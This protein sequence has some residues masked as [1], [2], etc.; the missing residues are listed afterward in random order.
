M[1]VIRKMLGTE[2]EKRIR[3]FYWKRG[4]GAI[5]PCG[6]KKIPS[7]CVTSREKVEKID[8]EKSA[9]FCVCSLCG[10]ALVLLRGGA[11]GSCFLCSGCCGDFINLNAAGGGAD[12]SEGERAR[13]EDALVSGRHL[14]LERQ[15]NDLLLQMARE[16]SLDRAAAAALFSACGARAALSGYIKDGLVGLCVDKSGYRMLPELVELLESG[17][18]AVRSL[19]GSYKEAELYFSLKKKSLFV[20]PKVPLCAVV[21]K[22]VAKN[23]FSEAWHLECFL[24]YKIDFVACSR[25]GVPEL[26]VELEENGKNPERKEFA[27]KVVKNAGLRIVAPGE[28]DV[29]DADL[30]LP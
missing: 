16:K 5:F 11:C 1:I 28:K 22:K 10:R 2:K 24:T 14:Q 12:L 18:T 3:R 6:P 9:G 15:D 26:L 20:F 29:A 21:P 30:T 19:F 7:R 27:E 25:G 4:A 23:V 17:R 8:S 13:M